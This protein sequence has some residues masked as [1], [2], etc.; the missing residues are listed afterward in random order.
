MIYHPNRF[1]AMR[2]VFVECNKNFA[3]AMVPDFCLSL[4]ETLYL[5]RNQISFDNTI[6]ANRLNMVC[7]IN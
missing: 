6:W 1:E 4:D 7:S 3:K 2:Y 5:M